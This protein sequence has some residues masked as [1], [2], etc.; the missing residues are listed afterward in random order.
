MRIRIM[1]IW[2]EYL[3]RLMP[4]FKDSKGR[5]NSRQGAR[6]QCSVGEGLVRV[7]ASAGAKA[8]FLLAFMARL[9]P[10]PDTGL[11]TWWEGHPGSEL[12]A[13][14]EKLGAAFE[15]RG[16]AGILRRVAAQNDAGRQ[17]IDGDKAEMEPHALIPRLRIETWGT[18]IF[19]A[20][21]IRTENWQ[22]RTDN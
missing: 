3:A 15:E 13:W 6:G 18:R 21:R 5:G 19:S 4:C 1:R 11:W 8:L 2:V 17:S 20:M 12:G 22:L 7:R 16:I 14:W 10:C 9:K